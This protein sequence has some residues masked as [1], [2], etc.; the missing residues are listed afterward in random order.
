MISVCMGYYNCDWNKRDVLLQ[1]TL[2]SISKSAV[3]DVEIIIIDD[4][5]P[6]KLDH[7]KLICKYPITVQR[8]ENKCWINPCIANNAA[9]SLAQGDKIVIQNPEC[10][11]VNDVLAFF[12]AEL[13]PGN[14]LSIACSALDALGNHSVWYNHPK[15]KPTGYPF[16]AGICKEDVFF[17]D[18][19]YRNG[20]CYEDDDY[21]MELKKCGI[22]I[23]NVDKV[24][25][26]HQWHGPSLWR[27][28]PSNEK[29][30][31][32]KWGLVH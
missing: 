5:S 17:F 29:L 22:K 32:H 13:T 20:V 8:L 10:R 19:A 16:C 28:M 9:L 25:V 18:T 7:K 4:Q 15:F 12:E 2:D 1:R 26:E 31:K 14:W 24:K 27:G 3:K 11:H 23:T 30:Y 21:V 6:K